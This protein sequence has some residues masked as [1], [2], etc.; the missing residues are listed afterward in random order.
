MARWHY[1]NIEVCSA[2]DPSEYCAD[3]KCLSVQLDRQIKVLGD[4]NA[5]DLKRNQALKWVVHLMGDLHQPLHVADNHDKGGNDVNVSFL[6]GRAI[7]LH[8]LWDTSMVKQMIVDDGGG[9][10]FLSAGINESD[11]ENWERGSIQAWLQE[12]HDVGVNVTYAKLSGFSCRGSVAGVTP[13]DNTYYKEAKQIIETQLRRAA[14]RLA[15]IL[16]TVFA[17]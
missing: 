2:S 15:K 12:T 1:D 5:A 9:A 11:K 7:N 4:T 14:V 8:A 6:G 13:I 3:G 17:E 10:T 16:N